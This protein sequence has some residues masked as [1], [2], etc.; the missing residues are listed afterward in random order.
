MNIL[1]FFLVVSITP[2]LVSC[3][4]SLS[5]VSFS[6]R[7]DL[8]PDYVP[9]NICYLLT[10]RSTRFIGFETTWHSAGTLLDGQYLLT[11]AH[12]LYDSWKSKPIRVAVTCK[13]KSGNIKTSII[14]QQ[15]IENT[16]KIA[17]YDYSFSQ[18]YAFI[19]LEYALDVAE[20]ISI[21]EDFDLSAI[22][23]I[24]V[25]GYPGGRLKYGKG[26]IIKPVKSKSTITYTI[27]TAKGMSGGPVWAGDRLVG[28][29]GFPSGGR[30]V[31]SALVKKY[32]EWKSQF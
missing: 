28:I 31:N 18:D 12:N 25:A 14:S 29:H 26:T 6:D 32:T 11:A 5:P 1:K 22:N 24:E 20:E 2:V 3:V 19:K 27:D 17:H 21:S 16:K 15:G 4:S 10:T 30:Q 13:E 8:F 23:E 7:S 9:T